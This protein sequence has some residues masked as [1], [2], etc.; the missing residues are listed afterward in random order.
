MQT[1]FKFKRVNK[2]VRFDIYPRGTGRYWVVWWYCGIYKNLRAGSQPNVLVALREYF[3]SGLMSDIVVYDRIPLTALGLFRIGT[4]WK[5][6]AC[7]AEAIF[8]NSKFSVDFSDKSW[9]LTSFDKS[10]FLGTTPPYPQD[11]YPLKHQKDQNWLLQFHL[12]TGGKLIIPC[13]EFFTRC[14]GRSSELR[15]VLATYPWQECI[16]NRLYAPIDE[17]EE[18][19]KWKIKLRMRLVNGD[20]VFLAHVKYETYAEKTAKS[21]YSQIESQYFPGSTKPIFIK[22]QPWFS[23]PVDL[24]ASGIW[25][26]EGRS[27]LALQINGSSDPKGVPILRDRDNTNLTDGPADAE[28]D[29]LDQAWTGT[30]GHVLINPP[31]IIDLTGD[32]EPDS[33]ALSVEIEDSEFEVLGN[34]R[35]VIAVRKD[36]ATGSRGPKLAATGASEYSS[37]EPQGRGHLVGHV[38]MHPRTIMES[39]GT[40]RD[41]WN[42]LLFLKNKY[43]DFIESVESYAFEDGYTSCIEPKLIGLQPFEDGAEIDGSTR[44]WP[45]IDVLS[46]VMRGVLVVRVLVC[47]KYIHILEIQRRSKKANTES[48][49]REYAEESFR[50]VV[51]IIDDK[52]RFNLWLKSFLSDVKY[53]KGVV[54]KVIGSFAGNIATFKHAPARD[55]EVL[56]EAAVL[57]ALK[58]MG[59][60]LNRK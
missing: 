38:S 53:V 24:K 56:C 36:Q 33:R 27:F 2:A 57:N 44:K 46:G 52:Q 1:N 30:A 43:P 58:K 6:G 51:L 7:R 34:P 20:V 12:P 55:E 49:N 18:E 23:G 4:V 21:I 28:S 5:D 11:I 26:D 16:N 48:D 10:A 19:N 37:G 14:Y 39:N 17:L 40:L 13:L 25:F 47:K 9:E 59:V 35:T 29:M 41:M 15:R 42:A 60:V 54:Q 22:I 31:D 8:S 45:Y 3:G 32:L 50:G